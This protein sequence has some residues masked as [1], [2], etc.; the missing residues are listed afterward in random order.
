ME[1]EATVTAKDWMNIKSLED[2]C[3]KNGTNPEEILPYKNPT[4]PKQVAMNGVAKVWEIVEAI[5]DGWVADRTKL[6]WFPV[7]RWTETG[8]VFSS[9]NCECWFSLSF[10]LV[11]A[12]FAIESD[13]KAEYIGKT[14]P[15]IYAEYIT[16]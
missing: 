9:T 16:R 12:P 15:H 6:R 10:A 1:K 5:N 13:E 11:G 4:T 14:F 3:R 2:A 8:L 7:F